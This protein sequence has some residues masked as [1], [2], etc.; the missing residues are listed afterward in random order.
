MEQVAR[1]LRDWIALDRSNMVSTRAGMHWV[2]GPFDYQTGHPP[3]ENP[4]GVPFYCPANNL[5]KSATNLG[6]A[7]T[8]IALLLR[9][10]LSIEH[11][12][13]LLHAPSFTHAARG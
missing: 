13:S 12:A 3:L 10:A 5:A 4:Q 2:I 7:A 1:V 6:R 8:S 9:D 11:G